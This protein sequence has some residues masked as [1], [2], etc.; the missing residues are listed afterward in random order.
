MFHFGEVRGDGLLGVEVDEGLV[1]V[2]GH[3][4]EAGGD[5]LAEIER[6]LEIDG[7]AEDLDLETGAVRYGFEGREEEAGGGGRWE[8]SG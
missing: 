3:L 4:G 6:L 5:F 1:D 8:W 7:G 2:K